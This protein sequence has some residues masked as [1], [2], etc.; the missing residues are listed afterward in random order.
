MLATGRK[1]LLNLFGSAHLQGL[2]TAEL[3]FI[4]SK[5]ALSDF[6]VC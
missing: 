6:C 4:F 2:K 3:D 1:M 5:K